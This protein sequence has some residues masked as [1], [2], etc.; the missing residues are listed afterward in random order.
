MRFDLEYDGLI[1][2]DIDDARAF[3]RSHQNTRASNREFLQNWLGVFVRAMLRPHNAEYTDLRI[4]RQATEKS[5][6]KLEFIVAYT[7]LLI[8][9]LIRDLF[10]CRLL[11]R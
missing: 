1:V 7:E 5:A 11:S 3:A 4:I 8:N 6:N 2:A 10:C 9:F